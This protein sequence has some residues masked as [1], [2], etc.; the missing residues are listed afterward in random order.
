M[1]KAGSLK[2]NDVFTISGTQISEIYV[3][4]KMTVHFQGMSKTLQFPHTIFLQG[5]PTCSIGIS[6]EGLYNR[7]NN[8]GRLILLNQNAIQFASAP[9]I[10]VDDKSVMLTAKNPTK[11]EGPDDVPALKNYYHPP[12]SEKQVS[13]SLAT[14]L[15]LISY[16]LDNVTVTRKLISPFLS[17]D[18][19]ALMPIGVEEFEVTNTSKKEHQITLVIP[20]P[21]LV[22]LQEKELKPTDQDTVYI[23][24]TPV[25][26]HIHKDFS[27][28]GIRGVVMASAECEDRMVIAVP[29]MAGV[30]ID[31]HPSFCLNRL[32]QDLLL[33]DD[34]SFYERERRFSIRIMAQPSAFPLH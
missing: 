32:K 29:E 16:K 7:L 11:A 13:L 22:N 9:F 26:G 24:A 3:K 2:I 4:N 5:A 25:K 20:R 12:I 19:Q 6:P 31:T 1:S 15:A 21:S 33:N 10:R 27:S 30:K 28:A 8:A 23:C 18:K 14:P 17:G 34:G